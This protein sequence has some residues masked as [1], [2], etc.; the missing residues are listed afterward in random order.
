MRAGGEVLTV[1]ARSPGPRPCGVRAC[2]AGR[3]SSASRARGSQSVRGETAAF[4][5]RFL[6]GPQAPE[7]SD[8]I[9]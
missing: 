3:A 1:S 4:L 5:D 7:T 8:E 6:A 2:P 9:L